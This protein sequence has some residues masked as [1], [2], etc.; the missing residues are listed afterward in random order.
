MSLKLAA[1]KSGVGIASIDSE[2]GQGALLEF[3]AQAERVLSIWHPVSH[4]GAPLKVAFFLEYFFYG[5]PSCEA[6]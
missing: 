5:G 4:G 1:E 6:V 2:V 3:L